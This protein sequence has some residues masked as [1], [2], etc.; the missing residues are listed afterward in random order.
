[1]QAAWLSNLYHGCTDRI[2]QEYRNLCEQISEV[3]VDMSALVVN[4]DKGQRLLE[5]Q[6]VGLITAAC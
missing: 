5:V 6:G 2:A 4:D 1:M 3:E